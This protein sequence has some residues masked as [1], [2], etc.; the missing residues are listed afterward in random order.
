MTGNICGQPALRTGPRRE[1]TRETET[2]TEESERGGGGSE[3]RREIAFRLPAGLTVLH[4][5][6]IFLLLF[7]YP[8]SRLIPVIVP[9]PSFPAMDYVCYCVL[10]YLA[11]TY[12]FLYV[13]HDT[14]PSFPI[15]KTLMKFHM[16]SI[17]PV[18]LSCVPS[19]FRLCACLVSPAYF[20]CVLVLCPQHISL[21]C[22]IC[23][24][25]MGEVRESLHVPLSHIVLPI[26]SH[27]VHVCSVFYHM[28][29]RMETARYN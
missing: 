8:I 27:A 17:S 29:S 6:F 22:L 20:A 14:V 10:R 11:S 26:C 1:D 21:V 4:H 15:S 5:G 7:Y 19:I 18:C 3:G 13:Q 25:S 9:L 12:N 2:M 16:R 28:S 23:V 24:P